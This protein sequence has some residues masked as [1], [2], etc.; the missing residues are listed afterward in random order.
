MPDEIHVL[1][2]GEWDH[3]AYGKIVI[4]EEKIGKFAE[5]FN[6]GIRRDLPITEGHEV[7]R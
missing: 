5:N 4:D 3:P 2:V 1:P 6:A 7:L